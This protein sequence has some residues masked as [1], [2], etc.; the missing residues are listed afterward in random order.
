MFI[1]LAS[2]EYTLKQNQDCV[3]MSFPDFKIKNLK[4]V[5]NLFVYVTWLFSGQASVFFKLERVW[6]IAGEL[7]RYRQQQFK[8][9]QLNWQ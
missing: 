8:C 6:K 2:S 5:S 9:K 7:S 4:E 3:H 1:A